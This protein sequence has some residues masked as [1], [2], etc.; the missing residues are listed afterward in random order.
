MPNLGEHDKNGKLASLLPIT[1]SISRLWEG[2]RS[3]EFDYGDK[4]DVKI[5]RILSTLKYTSGFPLLSKEDGDEVLELIAQ[6][7]RG[8][9]IKNTN[10]FAR[11][12]Y[13]EEKP[14]SMVWEVEDDNTLVV[15]TNHEHGKTYWFSDTVW[16]VDWEK[17]VFGR[18][19][20]P[21]SMEQIDQIFSMP[22]IS[23]AELDTVAPMLKEMFPVLPV[24][25]FNFRTISCDPVPC[26]RLISEKNENYKNRY[27]DFAVLEFD[28]DGARVGREK[29]ALYK[30]RRP[31][32][33]V[34]IERKSEK[35]EN[36]MNK[37]SDAGMELGSFVF[38]DGKEDTSELYYFMES[39]EEWEELARLQVPLLRKE[40][41]IVDID[42]SFRH[43]YLE[44]DSMEASFVEANNGWFDLDMGIVV[45][46]KRVSLAPILHDIFT[47]DFRWLH[48]EEIEKISDTEMILMRCEEGN[49]RVPA[50]R[51]KPL[52]LNLIELFDTDSKT[53]RMSK[54]DAGRINALADMSGWQFT[55]D[56]SIMAMAKKLM[57][58]A[59]IAPVTMPE[60]FPITL[61]PYQLDGVAWMQFLREHGLAGILADDM[62]IGKT[63]QMLANILLEKISGRM[64]SPVLVVIPTSLM[65]NWRTEAAR[66][67]PELKVVSW[68]GADRHESEHEIFQ[69]DIVLTTYT[70]V[71][72]DEEMLAKTN[73]HYVIL[74]EAQNAKNANSKTAQAIRK[75]PSNHRMAITGTP[76][77]NNLGELH[78]QFDFLLPGFLDS[79][80]TFTRNWRTPIEKHGN[81]GRRDLLA[82]RVKP[83]I[84]RRKKEEVAKDMP[85]KNIIIQTIAIEGGQRDLYENV[86]AAMD[87]KI[88]QEIESKGFARSQIVILD[89][90]LKLRQVCCDPRLLSLSSAQKVK[91][92][93]KLD[94]LTQMLSE[95]VQE[96]RRILVFSQFTSMLSLIEI[97][98]DAL[99]I[100]YVKLTGSSTKRE[101][102]VGRF[103]NREVPVF[104]I[105]LKAG[106]SGLNLNSADTVI[107]FDPWWSP[108]AE[109]QA[110]DRAH[111]LGK[112]ETLFV[113]KLV[114]A[115]SIEEKILA[116]QAKKQGLFD[117]ILSGDS[118]ALEKFG[119]SDI[120]ALLEPLDGHR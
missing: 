10:T 5:N 19:S 33:T 2:L 101:E 96:G 89:A 95:L 8:C 112:K 6:S 42:E 69:S 111:R 14:Y 71:W 94:R 113:Y 15:C 59:G 36:A 116:L 78:A 45:E 13:G 100:P 76:F 67:T 86:R 88:Q 103:E 39:P 3:G 50:G 34:R 68:H 30:L 102:I 84:L 29:P 62:G 53:I 118:N 74:D 99:N 120:R 44:I 114:I 115:G 28:Y 23:E 7:R 9:L 20:L 31:P 26:L 61:R 25:S 11:L 51:L 12:A 17:N 66:F 83:F 27:N 106:G 43:N 119:E 77:D 22:P 75:I 56:A 52:A 97:E 38:E 37:L 63:A 70:L 105:S 109:N 104:L 79:R 16:Y 47:R 72:R 54:M 93:A 1:H 35:E 110:T 91:E 32:E 40:G 24:P 58:S 55:G 48:Q 90:L 80:E 81:I 41:W 92:R 18:L 46:G 73:W 87:I 117:G 49:I 85:E 65:F 108:S 57:N 21:V 82:R 98:L 4:L 107:H 60:S 64:T